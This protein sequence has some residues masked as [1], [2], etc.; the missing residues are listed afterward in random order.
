MMM[1]PDVGIATQIPPWG[2]GVP[3]MGRSFNVGVNVK[4]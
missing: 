1:G 3:G 4:F 2:R